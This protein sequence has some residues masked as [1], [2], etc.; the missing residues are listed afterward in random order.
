MRAWHTDQHLRIRSRAHTLTLEIRYKHRTTEY[1]KP[2]PT[3]MLFDTA[4]QLNLREASMTIPSCQYNPRAR[5]QKYII[6]KTANEVS[7]TFHICRRSGSEVYMFRK[8]HTLAIYTEGQ[9][10]VKLA[11]QSYQALTDPTMLP[12]LGILFQKE[13]KREKNKNGFPFA[14]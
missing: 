11:A 8:R 10:S 5:K 1:R 2:D 6:N 9:S 7:N 3:Y 13:G 12:G 14:D 4:R